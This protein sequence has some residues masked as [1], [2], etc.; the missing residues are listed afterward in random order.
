[1][2]KDTYVL[3]TGLSHD[4][5]ACLLKNGKI[6][7]AIEKE[8]VTRV[9]HDGHNDTEAIMYCLS[10]E[11]I[12]L[13]DLDLIVQNENFHMFEYGN[14]FYRGERLFHSDLDV[15]IVTISHHLA[16]AYS[17]IGTCPFDD[18]NVLV[19][20]GCGNS[21]DQCIDLSNNCLVPDKNMI[22]GELAH[23]FMEKDSYYGFS[24]GE[25]T[26]LLKDFSP[27]GMRAK[28][29]IMHP[30][31]T[32]HS[33]GGIYAAASD[34]CFGNLDDVGKLMGLAPYGKP[35]RFNFQVFNLKDGRIFVNYDI[36]KEFK[37]PSRSTTMFKSNFQYYADMAYWI[38]NE[39]ERA[40]IYVVNNRLKHNYS[41]NLCFA[42]GV[43]LNAVAN[44]R[45]IA[46]TDVKNLYLQPAA[47]DN[48]LAIGCAFYGWMEVLKQKRIIHDGSS[49][50]GIEYSDREIIQAAKEVNN[51]NNPQII[52]R[53]ID[54][55][56]KYLA[57]NSSVQLTQNLKEVI[58]F[59][60]GDYGIYQVIFE[61]GKPR[62]TKAVEKS[63]TGIVTIEGA[64][65]YNG[66]IDPERFNALFMEQKIQF[67]NQF[68]VQLMLGLI[69]MRMTSIVL[70]NYS[71]DLENSENNE[72]ISIRRENNIVKTTA[73]LL[74]KGKIIGW[75][76]GGSEFGPRALGRRSILADPRNPA[77]RD[78]INAK[79]KFRED[80]RPFAPS[81]LREDASIYF[82][83]AHDS[84]YM[85]LVS[86]VKEDWRKKLASVTH[87]N[88]SARV[89][90]VTKDWNLKYYDLLS[91]FKNQTGISVLLNTSFNR[92][93]MPIVE[94]PKQAMSFFTECALDHVVIGDYLISRRD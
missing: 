92:K 24:N 41:E 20:D 51:A 81:V 1:M 3:G 40:L 57:E 82:D 64:D 43:A 45:I 54:Q 86:Q 26:P 52:Q 19:I 49:C 39:V 23:L 35:G 32:M 30:G 31:T 50:F 85:I 94:T 9:K 67:T 59:N 63:P 47:G 33:I 17:T 78:F 29:N 5:S 18:F 25:L 58:Q 13:N 14:E 53:T 11:G 73:D 66:L 77:F 46:E 6:C 68:H 56:F 15:P 83:L 89:Q 36:L 34:Y 28:N 91:E 88:N 42:G 38:Q 37:S 44:S 55:Y 61:F 27:W 79:V 22:T 72:I 90:T 60:L 48:G 70:R 75:F 21:Y 84:P 87:V 71:K 74:A 4:G 12:S 7:V 65:F 69:D 76:Q 8:R 16:H 2:K 62:I 93:G 10:A 80:F